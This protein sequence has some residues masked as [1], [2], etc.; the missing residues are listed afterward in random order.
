[1]DDGPD[2]FQRQAESQVRLPKVVRIVLAGVVLIGAALFILL[3]T[4]LLF[5]T[6]RSQMPHPMG[7]LLMT[8]FLI[9]LGTAFA[10]IGLRLLRIRKQTDSLMSPRGSRI[11]SYCVA[12][13]GVAMILGGLFSLNLDFAVAGLFAFLMA[14]WLHGST[15]RTH[16]EV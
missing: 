8:L 11:A 16:H 15:K 14:Y 5:A 4:V 9:V 3:G 2:F 6:D 12:A 7:T 13:I 1:M 10:Y